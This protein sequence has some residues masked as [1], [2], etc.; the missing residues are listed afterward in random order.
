MATL[1][2]S[3]PCDQVEREL[4]TNPGSSLTWDYLQFH[5]FLDEIRQ[6]RTQ[7]VLLNTMLAGGTAAIIIAI[8]IATVALIWFC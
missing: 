5:T 4:R 7:I 1:Q 6:L 8:A 2:T 3:H